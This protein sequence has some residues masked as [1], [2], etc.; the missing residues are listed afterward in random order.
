[1]LYRVTAYRTGHRQGPVSET[2]P[3]GGTKRSRETPTHQ[4]GGWQGPGGPQ[5][6]AGLWAC[7]GQRLLTQGPASSSWQPAGGA[8]ARPRCGDRCPQSSGSLVTGTRRHC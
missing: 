8:G 3:T 1:M 5:G 7:A 4:G 2:G 6:P